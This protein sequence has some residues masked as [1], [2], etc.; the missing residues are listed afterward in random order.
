MTTTNTSVPEPTTDHQETEK[1]P[2]T[3]AALPIHPAAI[4][5]VAGSDERVNVF[6]S[7]AAF[8]L[9]QREA[10]ALA[11]GT[12][13]PEQYR[14]NIPNCLLALELSSRINV[15]VFAVMQNIDIIH[16][17]PGWRATFLI[18]TVN[19][20]GRF[21]PL[22]FRWEGKEGT[23]AFGCRAVAKDR[24][25]G[26]ELI[27]TVITWSMVD[28]EGWSKK[29]G[30][31]WRTMPEQMFMYRAAAFWTR[32]YAPELSLGM[33]TADEQEDIGGS[34]VEV[35]ARPVKARR[36]INEL[37]AS[38]AVTEPET[39]RVDEEVTA[40]EDPPEYD[41]ENGE[42]YDGELPDEYA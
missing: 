28:A 19:A 15:S 12:M 14:N 36:G 9:A 1:R 30:S 8:E 40:R 32:V 21:S 20:C 18:A 25:S 37:V 17:R 11:A 39:A 4:A 23:P 31:K 41:H 29:S 26:E 38:A 13:V 22:R 42:V 34:T 10:K 24:E 6:S 3:V 16:G 35:Q 33:H 7:S 2:A 5:A 27:G